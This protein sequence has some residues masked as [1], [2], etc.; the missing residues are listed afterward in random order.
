MLLDWLRTAQLDRV[1]CFKYSPVEGAAANALPDPVP[2]EVKQD[3]WDR[4]MEVAAAISAQKLA[5][6]VGRSTACAR[7]HRRAQ[8]GRRT[9]VRR[10]ARDRRRRAD[11]R[12]PASSGPATG[13]MSRSPAPMPT[14]SSAGSPPHDAPAPE[15]CCSARRC[16]RHS[17]SARRNRW[18]IRSRSRSANT[19]TACVMPSCPMCMA[20]AWSCA[21]RSRAC[22]R[23]A[24]SEAAG[25]IRS[26]STSSSSHS[27][28]SSPTASIRATTTST[29]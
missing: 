15:R 17:S 26:G 3:R 24:S 12:S 6:K 5:A 1:G 11:R 23:S 4:F 27:P 7:R 28:T 9:L 8:G 22:T 25:P 20:R 19:S 18:T 10:R 29:R 13:P 2:E 16:S 21:I 14:T